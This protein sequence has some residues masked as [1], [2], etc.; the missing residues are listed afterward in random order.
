MKIGMDSKVYP[1]AKLCYRELISIGSRVIIDDFV[2]IAG[3]SGVFIGDFVHIGAHSLISGQGA[4]RLESFSGL[5]SGVRLFS[6][7]EIFDG[8]NLTNP[9]IPSTYRKVKSGPIVI[10]RHAV[11]CANSVIMPNVTIG[12]GAV[13][14]ANSLV[15]KSVEPWGIYQGTPLRRIK[16]RKSEKILELEERLRDQGK[17]NEQ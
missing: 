17:G 7:T 16:T 4:I 8:D 3:K 13:I 1:S 14:G 11:V 9:T 15:T 6:S 10:C 2:F 5:S 12:E